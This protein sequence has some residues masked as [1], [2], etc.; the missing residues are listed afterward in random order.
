MKKYSLITLVFISQFILMSCEQKVSENLVSQSPNEKL[1]ISIVATR[2]TSLDP[3]AVSIT[4]NN[5]ETGEKIASVN[6]EIQAEKIDAENVTFNWVGE[7]SCEL[8]FTQADGSVIK[9][10]VKI[11]Y[12]KE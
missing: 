12:Q 5:T 3:W 2:Y 11:E 6:Q 1:E 4:L 10:P 8:L 9:V 7:T